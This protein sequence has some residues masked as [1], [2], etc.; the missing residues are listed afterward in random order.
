MGRPPGEARVC[1]GVA[2]ILHLACVSTLS[3][4]WLPG[5]ANLWIHWSASRQSPGRPGGLT[6]HVPGHFP[7]H[8]WLL[9]GTSSALSSWGDLGKSRPLSASQVLVN[10][11]LD[12]GTSWVPGPLF[13]EKEEGM[14]RTS[15]T[16]WCQ[17]G[18][19]A[20][21]SYMCPR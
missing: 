18:E 12:W 13:G 20:G 6:Q 5:T 16:G 14:K 21:F 8:L 3:P 2:Q 7:P 15:H 17:D 4:P 9:S 11:G 1:G 10:T 19:H